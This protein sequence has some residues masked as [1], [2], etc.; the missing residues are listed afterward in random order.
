MENPNQADKH[1]GREDNR[2]QD[3]QVEVVAEGTGYKT[4]QGWSAHAADISRQGQE[5]KHGCSASPDICGRQAE[6][7]GPHDADREACEGAAKEGK[8]RDSGKRDQ[9]IAQD[10]EQGTGDHESDQRDL[11]TEFPV[12]SP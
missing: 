3:A 9:E 1:E 5:G 7:P 6:S 2:A 10:A 12:E 11:F 8:C 4:G